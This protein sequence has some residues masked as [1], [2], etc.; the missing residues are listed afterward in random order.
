M[1]KSLREIQQEHHEWR[2]YNFPDQTPD[3]AFLG[4]TEEMGEMAHAQLKLA[5]GIRGMTEEQAMDAIIDGHCDWLIF[6]MGFAN[7]HGYD[8]QTQLNRVWEKV[9]SRDWIKNPT[10]AHEVAGD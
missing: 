10:N 4:M 2:L 5:Q 6:S 1:D 3:Q 7:A 9:Q 8:I